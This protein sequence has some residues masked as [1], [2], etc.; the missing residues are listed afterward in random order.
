M[1]S[2]LLR[3]PDSLRG[4]LKEPWGP[5]FTDAEDLLAEAGEPTLVEREDDLQERVRTASD[6]AEVGDH[7]SAYERRQA[8]DGAVGRT[9]GGRQSDH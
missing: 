6:A 8:R 2:V 3:L 9:G 5:V 1:A 7:R 4:E